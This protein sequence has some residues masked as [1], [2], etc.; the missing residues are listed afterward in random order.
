MIKDLEEKSLHE[1]KKVSEN[2]VN[3]E[4]LHMNVALNHK[5][6]MGLQ[7]D[8]KELIDQNTR[9]IEMLKNKPPVEI[10]EMPDVGDGLNMAQLMNIFAS[11][12]PPDSTIVR[13]EELEK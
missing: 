1:E 10:P 7:E 9:D 2:N 8:H 5:T 13:I 11:K 6:I 12:N 3:I 4:N